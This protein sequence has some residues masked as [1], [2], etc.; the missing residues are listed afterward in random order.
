[1]ALG[2]AVDS[3]GE[4]AIAGY[5]QGSVD[6]G[7]GSLASAGGSDIFVAKY[8]AGGVPLWSRRVGASQDDRAQGIAVDGS[9]NV[10]V[11]GTFQG[12]VD[13]GG[14]AVSSTATYVNSFLV[15]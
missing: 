13:F 12:T 1:V 3:L 5:M 2:V 14:G 10:Y 4:I 9:G 8:T 7:T 6:L 11:I 15:K